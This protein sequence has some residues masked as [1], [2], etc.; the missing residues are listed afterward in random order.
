[1]L[2]IPVPTQVQIIHTLLLPWLLVLHQHLRCPVLPHILQQPSLLLQQTLE[3]LSQACLRQPPLEYHPHPPL[4][5]LRE[6]GGLQHYLLLSFPLLMPDTLWVS[7]LSFSSLSFLLSFFLLND[8]TPNSWRFTNTTLTTNLQDINIDR[9]NSHK[10]RSLLIVTLCVPSVDFVFICCWFCQTYAWTS[11]IRAKR[12]SFETWVQEKALLTK[13]MTASSVR[14]E[15]L[16]S[17][18]KFRKKEK[19]THER[20]R[21][22]KRDEK[23]TPGKK[24]M[25][26]QEWER[27]TD[28][29]PTD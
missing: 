22:Q 14:P 18:T 10:D 17:F 8:F 12:V 27:E 15:T 25:R 29:K 24:K 23:E 3:D 6:E 5:W 21:H 19:N 20:T 11:R 26:E 28:N 1:M 9:A 16:K 4:E 13:Q 2:H 7:S